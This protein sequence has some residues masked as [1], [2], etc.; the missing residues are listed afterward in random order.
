AWPALAV[1][2]RGGAEFLL[3]RML[4]S[5]GRYPFGLKELL[6]ALGY[7]AAVVLVSW[8]VERA[9]LLCFIFIAYA[10]GCIG[11][12]LVPS[13]VGQNVDRFRFVAVP[14]MVLS[15]SLRR[16]Q[17]RMVSIGLL[18]LAVL[19]NVLPLATGFVNRSEPAAHA[20]YWQPA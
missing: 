11:A 10:A 5:S 20:A 15:L 17:P 2:L 14:V 16:W 4:P 7:C 9:R 6:W 1:A 8:R 3:W 13:A 12:F 19:W 18:P